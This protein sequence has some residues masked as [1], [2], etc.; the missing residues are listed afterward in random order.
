MSKGSFGFGLVL[1]AAAG[2]VSAY[3]FAPK[4]GTEFQAELTDK[5]NETKNKAIL[6]L[7]EAVT[8]AEIWVD[9]KLTE[10][11]IEN[12]PVVYERTAETVSTPPTGTS[13]DDELKGI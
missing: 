11:S 3:L 7:D 6:A 9:N 2:A 13:L 8:E 5:A 4:S 1:G 10:K 12:E